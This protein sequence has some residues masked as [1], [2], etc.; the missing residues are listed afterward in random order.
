MRDFGDVLPDRLHYQVSEEMYLLL[1]QWLLPFGLVPLDV[2][3]ENIRVNHGDTI[4][5]DVEIGT[6]S[7]LD[8]MAVLW[9]LSN[10]YKGYNR[11]PNYLKNAGKLANRLQQWLAYCNERS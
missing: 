10:V 11:I 8:A 2:D 1:L 4:W 5:I 7:D 3:R 6:L 9:M